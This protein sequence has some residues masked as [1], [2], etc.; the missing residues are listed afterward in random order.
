MTVSACSEGTVILRLAAG[1]RDRHRRQRQRPDRQRDG[2]HRSHRPGRPPSTC[3]TA[4][5]SG[6]SDTDNITNGA[7]PDLRRHLR[8]GRLRPHRQPTSATPAPPP[9]ASSALRC[10]SGDS[11]RPSPSAPAPRAPSSCAWP[12]AGVTDT[13]GNDQRPDRQPTVTIDR[14]D[15]E[16]PP[17]ICRP[18]SDSGTSNTDNITNGAQPDLR[19]RL[20]RGRLR[21][22]RQRLQQRRH[23]HRLHFGAPMGSG[24]SYTVTVSACS[25]GTVILRLAA[26]RR[27]RHRRQRQRPDRRRDGDHRSHRPGASGTPDL[28]R[29][30]RLRCSSTDNLTNVNTP[31]FT[32]TAEADSLVTIYVDGVAKGSGVGDWRQLL[33]HDRRVD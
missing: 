24:D 23:R 6:T 7:Q 15:P 20:R 11:L 21:P 12:P 22:G 33:D 8:R 2:D 26:G 17:S 5:D 4:S 19:R 16:S 30:Q 10:G 32:G 18:A 9:A 31:T 28:D 1:R 27:D 25:E 13:A 3:R 29:C 14:T